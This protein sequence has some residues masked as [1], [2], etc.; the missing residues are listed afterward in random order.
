MSVSDRDAPPAALS[1]EQVRAI[2]FAVDGLSDAHP[3]LSA[4]S[5]FSLRQRIL[6]ALVAVGFVAAAW[7]VPLLL[8]IGLMTVM[9]TVYTAV[10][11]LRVDLML[12]SSDH[13][14]FSFTRE[15]LDELDPDTLPTFTIL[16]PAYREPEV[17]HTSSA[18]SRRSST[19]T[20]ACRSS[21]CSRR[22]TRRH[23]RRRPRWICSHRSRSSSSLRSGRAR[24]RRRSTT[25]CSTPPAT[26]CASTTRR[27][28]PTRCS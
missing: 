4:R 12:R 24:S 2:D 25:H 15:E 3:V 9:I 6:F 16:V 17:L 23:E 5:R 27:T 7:F 13:G 22:T 20:T 10:I 11:G 8:G 21:C 14:R 19:H 26:S 28:G 18:T 1:D